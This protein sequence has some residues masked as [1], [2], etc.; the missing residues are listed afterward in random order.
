MT[1]H[2]P[3]FDIDITP[4]SA[5]RWMMGRDGAFPTRVPVTGEDVPLS[6]LFFLRSQPAAG[7]SI[8]L[9]LAATRTAGSLAASATCVTAV[10]GSATD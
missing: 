7:I 3:A 1:D 8:M 9:N 6:Y 4:E 10:S 2:L 5:S